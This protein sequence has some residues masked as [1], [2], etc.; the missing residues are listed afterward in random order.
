M[1][2]GAAGNE[3]PPATT[4]SRATRPDKLQERLALV[5]AEPDRQPFARL[6]VELFGLL[7]PPG[8]QARS[9]AAIFLGRAPV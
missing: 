1:G 3:Q 2:F 8:S 5:R 4:T 9:H 6:A 7:R